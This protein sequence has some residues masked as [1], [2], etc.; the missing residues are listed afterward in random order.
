MKKSIILRALFCVVLLM[1]AAMMTADE[2]YLPVTF[3]A[4]GITFQIAGKDIVYVRRSNSSRKAYQGDMV[5]PA[6]CTHKGT[7]YIVAGIDEGAFQNCKK[8]TSVV[9]PDSLEYIGARAF[10][11]C[12]SLTAI[13]LP[14]TVKKIKKRAFAHC[15]QLKS[16]SIGAG[17][18]EIGEEAFLDCRNIET[19]YV[20]ASQ[21]PKTDSD[22]FELVPQ[23]GITLYVPA[24]AVKDYRRI[25]PWKAFGTV[26]PLE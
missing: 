24:D 1:T 21:L 19:L 3:E 11:G 18:E 17:I 25:A 13:V 2:F 8:L 10:D 23:S 12:S 20:R 14:N 16:A 26:L 22:A 15:P 7:R 4:D 9:I 5:I 6:S